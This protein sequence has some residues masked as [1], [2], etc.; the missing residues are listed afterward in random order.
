MRTIAIVM[1]IVFHFIYDLNEFTN[2]T[3][4]IK[5]EGMEIFKIITASLFLFVAGI[6]TNFS[7]NQFKRALIVIGAGIIITLTTYIYNPNTFIRFG[8]LHCI[9]VGMLIL[10]PL[11][12]LKEL[13]ILLGLFILMIPIQFPP[14]HT[15]LDYYPLL[16]WLAV[17]LIGFGIGHYLFVRKNIFQK[18]SYSKSLS[19]LTFLG[20]HTL[21][22][23]MIHQPIIIGVLMIG[24]W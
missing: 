7:K 22:I 14:P 8:I 16:P 21:L 12:K 11:N 19:N 9:G 5:S 23:Y 10:I 1:M 20:R 6:S 13:N 24:N 17:M 3:I 2:I 4:N 15:T 18:K